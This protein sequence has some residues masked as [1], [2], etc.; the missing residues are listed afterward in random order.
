MVQ[1]EIFFNLN[2]P[3]NGPKG[4]FDQNRFFV[5]LNRRITD[6]LSVDMGYQLQVLETREPGFPDDLNHILL[7][8]FF[9]N[10]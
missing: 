1:D 5:G 4:G 2:S 6:H 8:Q 3:N 7:F 10:M 9:L